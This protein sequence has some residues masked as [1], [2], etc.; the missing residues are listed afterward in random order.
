MA[1][2]AS[3]VRE[4]DE[5]LFR[6]FFDA[7]L[8]VKLSNARTQD[9][10]VKAMDGLLIT[11]GDDISAEF[12]DQEIPDPSLIRDP[13]PD[14]DAWEFEALEYALEKGKPVFAICRGHQMLNVALGGTMLLD[15]KG[16]NAPELKSQNLQP[17]R[18]AG[19]V[20]AR[21][22]F[23]QVNSSHHQ[24]IDKLGDGLEVEAWCA[25]DDIVEQVRI[26]DYPYAVGVQYHPERDWLYKNLFEDFFNQVLKK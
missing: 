11:G 20:D 23:A 21:R 13:M 15:I 22:K 2:V 10:D 9:V 19:D 4:S 6:R 5:A 18:Y 14:R 17:L 7:Y 24:A 16:H 1:N 26:R 8:G 3:W 12:L 25:A